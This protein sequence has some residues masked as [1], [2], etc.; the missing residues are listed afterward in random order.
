V[1]DR[2]AI[3]SARLRTANGKPAHVQTAIAVAPAR[4]PVCPEPLAITLTEAARLVGVNPRTL[5]KWPLPFVTV[6]RVVRV[7]L[8]DLDDFLLAHRQGVVR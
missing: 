4:S 3:I 7:R 2:L 6:G 8:S 1:N 5:R